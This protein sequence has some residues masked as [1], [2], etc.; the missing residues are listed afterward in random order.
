MSGHGHIEGGSNK[1]IAILIAC[2]AAL[3]AVTETGAKSSQTA[4]L[5]EHIEASNLWNFY[6][7]KTIR[8]TVLRT[9]ADALEAAYKDGPP[10]PA[11]VAAQAKQ[12]KATADRY[13]SEPQQGKGEGR[14]ELM[15][16]ALNHEKQRDKAS[17]AYHLFEYG[18]ASLQLAIVLAS[19]AAVTSVMWL[20]FLS[21]GLGLVGAAFMLVG[22]IA[23]T[24]IHL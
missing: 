2:L 4:V 14:K 12:W 3:L 18:S 6:Q 22:F 5:G 16:R 1:R 8:Q 23:P 24:L 17:S 20:A 10:A 13:E 15:A 21:G 7:A 11:P 19:A 9:Q